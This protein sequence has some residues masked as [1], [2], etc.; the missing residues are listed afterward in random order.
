MRVFQQLSEIPADLGPTIVSVGN[1]DGVHRAHQSVLQQVVAR[2]KELKATSVAVTFEPHPT[3]I[4]RPENA[5]RLITPLAEKLK[6]LQETGLGATLIL[7]FNRDLSLMKPHDFAAGILAKTLHACEV[8]EGFNFHFG[9]KAEGNL[10]RLAEFGKELGF[11]VVPYDEM[12]LRG[13]TV[14]STS[15][16]KLLQAGRVESAR[17]LLG[18]VFSIA[19]TPGRGRG[20]GHKYTVPT[21]NL[22]RYDELV[23]GNGVYVTRTRVGSE[24]FDSV[25]NIGNRPTFGEESF[26]IETH[27]LNFHPIEVTAETPVELA[28]LKYLRPEM[29]WPD[30]D[31]L[32]AQIAK[33]VHRAR[34][35]FH[36]ASL[37]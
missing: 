31:S 33:D 26:A 37:M 15:I 2:A 14:S 19:S 7:P 22:A 12:T 23:P 6:R 11:D 16:R 21:I 34:R 28:F 3:R 13:H 25:T 8:H 10:P 24:T 4:L 20:Y 1:F 30:V 32:R 36:L 9:H 5:P 17:H 35:Y 29:K 18:R 27:L